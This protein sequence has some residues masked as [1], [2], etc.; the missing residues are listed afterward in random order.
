[1]VAIEEIVEETV[2]VSASEERRLDAESIEAAALTMERVSARMQLE[3][4]AKRLR[5]ESEAL[6]RVEKSRKRAS[7]DSG[8]R[9]ESSTSIPAAPAAIEKTPKAKSTAAAPAATPIT[10]SSVS[11]SPPPPFISPTVKY[12]PV[13]KFAFGEGGYS[14]PFVTL[15]IDL[16][17]VGSI[18]RENIKC[19][20]TKDSIDLIV[21]DLKGKSYR[22]FKDSLEKDIVVE[23]SKIVVKANKVLVKLAKVKSEYGGGYDMWTKLTDSKKKKEKSKSDPQ[24]SIMDLMRD[25]YE[26]GDDKMKKMIG[27]TMM[28]QQRGETGNDI[29]GMGDMGGMGG[30]DGLGDM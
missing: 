24:G 27:E 29:G 4:L 1:M 18:P 7:E 20:F 14:A 21:N 9:E 26:G 11:P 2:T 30:L 10:S 15:Y 8:V 19:Q 3:A 22:L 17:G 5:K 13:H 6:A 12:I 23:K 16:E 25:M 28:K